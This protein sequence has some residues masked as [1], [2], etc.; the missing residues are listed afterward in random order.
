VGEP[1]WWY[2][3]NTPQWDRLVMDAE[4]GTDWEAL[5]A[6][7]RTGQLYYVVIGRP[8][9]LVNR[10]GPYPIETALGLARET[11]EWD[12]RSRMISPRVVELE[13]AP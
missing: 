11:M 7:A 13:L 1:L 9:G 6:D 2:E 10:L 4:M 12:R 5:E 3:P 8:S